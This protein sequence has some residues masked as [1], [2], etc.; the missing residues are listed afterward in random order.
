MTEQMVARDQITRPYDPSTR[1]L[2]LSVEIMPALVT[3]AYRAV[4]IN[5]LG[6]I[7]D[8]TIEQM[9]ERQH[10][11]LLQACERF[12]RALNPIHREL[13][14]KLASHERS[15]EGAIFRY[16]GLLDTPLE[17]L[18]SPAIQRCHTAATNKRE[19][20]LNTSSAAVKARPRYYIELDGRLAAVTFDCSDEGRET[21]EVD[22]QCPD[23]G[24]ATHWSLERIGY[25]GERYYAN[26]D[27]GNAY[28]VE[29]R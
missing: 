15:A 18:M 19:E 10:R 5:A 16:L 20:I 22:A 8:V 4:Q 25:C 13:A 27:C 14:M 12:V 17:L 3:L 24:D 28:R 11:P 21:I 9:P 23:C 1:D 29:G 2:R 6:A 7:D 26:C